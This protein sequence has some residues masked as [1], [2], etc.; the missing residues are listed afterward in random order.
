MQLSVLSLHLH[1]LSIEL[2]IKV[3]FWSC[4]K[5]IDLKYCKLM[6]FTLLCKC[7]HNHTDASQSGEWVR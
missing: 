4:M 2:S 5:F 7:K 6:Q 1:I 3:K